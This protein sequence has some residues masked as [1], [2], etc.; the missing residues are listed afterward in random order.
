MRR[1]QQLLHARIVD[2]NHALYFTF[3]KHVFTGK[4]IQGG[5][6]SQCTWQKPGEMP[7]EI[8]HHNTGLGQQPYVRTFESLTD[9]TETCIQECLDEYHTRY[10]SWKRVRHRPS[11]KP[12]E[13]LF[14]HLQRRQLNVNTPAEGNRQILL[15]EQIASQKAH[16]EHLTKHI[17]EWHAWYK[18]NFP[19]KEIPVEPIEDEI[20]QKKEDSR[21]ATAQPFILHSDEGQYLVL[22]RLNEVAPK[23]CISWLKKIGPESFKNRLND[24]KFQFDPMT[25]GSNEWNPVDKETSKRFVHDFFNKL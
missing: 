1:L 3:K 19:E 13:V 23:E 11:D 15:F 18:L 5:L 12:M 24:V 9:W 20:Q 4:I 22:H 2:I 14:K 17:K 25:N 8:F 10:S 21:E 7:H 16:I 6:I